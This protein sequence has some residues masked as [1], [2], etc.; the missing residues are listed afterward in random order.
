M[1]TLP[2][3]FFALGGA[4]VIVVVVAILGV[5]ATNVWFWIVK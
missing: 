5:V 1:Q 3:V 2:D 4:A